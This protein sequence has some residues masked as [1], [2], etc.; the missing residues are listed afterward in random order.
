MIVQLPHRWLLKDY[1]SAAFLPKCWEN[2]VFKYCVSVT[3]ENSTHTFP[4]TLN[5]RIHKEHLPPWI[6]QSYTPL[7]RASSFLPWQ[8]LF[9]TGTCPKN[10]KG[11]KTLDIRRDSVCLARSSQ[12]PYENASS[13]SRQRAASWTLL[14]RWRD[15][16]VVLMALILSFTH[17]MHMMPSFTYMSLQTP[18][19]G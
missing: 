12:L 11:K 2:R 13:R 9:S 6:I 10:K 3:Q 16:K 8:N 17:M 4:V 14:A 7:Q 5:P 15:L 1:F 18:T 19:I